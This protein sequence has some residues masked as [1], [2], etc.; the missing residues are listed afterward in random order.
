MS[1]PRDAHG[2]V[3]TKQRRLALE[4]DE[5]VCQLRLA[6]CLIAATEADHIHPRG[7]GGTH[8]LA[9]IRSVCSSCHKKRRAP[10]PRSTR[11]W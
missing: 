8:D 3:W 7:K 5:Y 11:E 1:I 10:G 4:R 9:N 6:G 2:R